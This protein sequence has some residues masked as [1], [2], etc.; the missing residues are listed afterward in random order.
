MF[1][2]F[3]C[4]YNEIRKEIFKYMTLPWE[5]IK[6]F[7]MYNVRNLKFIINPFDQKHINGRKMFLLKHP[8][9][10]SCP[11]FRFG[12]LRKWGEKKRLNRVSRFYHIK[13]NLALEWWKLKPN[14]SESLCFHNF[15]QANELWIL[16][17]NIFL[18]PLKTPRPLF[19]IISVSKIFDTFV[20]RKKKGIKI[21]DRIC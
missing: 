19:A 17:R 10:N 14:C 12:K 1:A 7:H 13:T 2:L 11:L 21:I 6:C 18:F 8:V 4:Y 15:Q 5:Y 9:F 3:M 16:N 20:D